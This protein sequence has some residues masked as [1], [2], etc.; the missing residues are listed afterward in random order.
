MGTARLQWH[1]PSTC[2]FCWGFLLPVFSLL[3]PHPKDGQLNVSNDS[4][5]K[6]NWVGGS[7]WAA[8]CAWAACPSGKVGWRKPRGCERV[9]CSPAQ[10]APSCHRAAMTCPHSIRPRGCGQPAVG[11]LNGF[12]SFWIPLLVSK[13][14]WGPSVGGLKSPWGPHGPMWGTSVGRSAVPVKS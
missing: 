5:I 4:G 2:C 8:G 3:L 11:F 13:S 14:S 7:D 6:L 9:R 10:P 12:S 1:W